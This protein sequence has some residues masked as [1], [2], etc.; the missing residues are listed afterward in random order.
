MSCDTVA[1]LV[2][3]ICVIVLYIGKLFF[4]SYNGKKVYAK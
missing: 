4:V 1:I 3:I 2:V